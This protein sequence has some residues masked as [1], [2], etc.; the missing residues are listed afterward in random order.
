MSAITIQEVT[1]NVFITGEGVR[2]I[3]QQTEPDAD[4][5]DVYHKRYSYL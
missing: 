1:D 5:G 2:S 3:E 4:M